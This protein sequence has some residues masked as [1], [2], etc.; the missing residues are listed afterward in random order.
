M[1]KENPLYANERLREERINRN[2]SQQKLADE[3][4]V[5]VVMVKNW[6]RG[7]QPTDYYCLKLCTFFGKSAE[8]L[9][10][11]EELAEFCCKRRATRE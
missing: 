10:L 6:E 8:E 2:W 1:P 11:V 9:G 4:G 5:A 7:K 3:L